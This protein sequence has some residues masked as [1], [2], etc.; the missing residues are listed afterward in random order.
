VEE[1]TWEIVES[2]GTGE[3]TIIEEIKYNEE[4]IIW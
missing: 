2:T 3:E 4:P 1:L